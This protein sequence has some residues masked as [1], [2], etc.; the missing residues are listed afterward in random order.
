MCRQRTK[1]IIIKNDKESDD[2]IKIKHSVKHLKGIET[3][4]KT[5]ESNTSSYPFFN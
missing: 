1:E 2:L 5:D 3:C 4:Q